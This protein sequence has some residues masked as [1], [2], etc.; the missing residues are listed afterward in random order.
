MVYY[1]LRSPGKGGKRLDLVLA[2]Y[3]KLTALVELALA[4]PL[5]LLVKLTGLLWRRK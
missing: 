1:P 2:T 3:G 5:S 4:A